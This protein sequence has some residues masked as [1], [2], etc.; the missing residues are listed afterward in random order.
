MKRI[1]IAYIT[2][3][4]PKDKT[5]WSGVH[6]FAWKALERNVGDVDLLGPVEAPLTLFLCKIL[7]GLS[8]LVLRKR[9]NYR[10]SVILSKAYAGIF[11]K[12]FGNTHYDLIVAPGG[13]AYI[14]FLQTTIPIFYFSDAT[15]ANLIN[16][17]KMLTNLLDWSRKQSLL[18]EQQAINTASFVS[19][20]SQWAADSALKDFHCPPEK[21]KVLPFGANFET[22]PDRTLA[23]RPR[24]DKVCKLF[25]LGVDWNHK[26]GP[27][28][29]D[30]LIEL[31]NLGIDA[32]LTVVGC[33]VP[34]EINHPKLTLVPFLSKNNPAEFRQLE[35]LYLESS[36]FLLPT[37]TE[38]YGICF[39]EAAAYGLPSI[40]GNSGGVSSSIGQGQSGYLLPLNAGGKEYAHLI[41]EIWNDPARYDQ[42]R[43]SSRNLFEQGRNWNAWSEGLREMIAKKS[44]G[45]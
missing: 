20:S 14:A 38:C 28:A 16:Y 19:Y 25:F 12:K 26:G 10:H 23:I 21:L 13:S 11:R 1:K 27:V 32:Q 24:E 8:M 31:L 3:L 22:A 34:P 41:A 2:G 33:T 43:I 15:N 37:R 40:A 39:C 17:R 18:I 30:T 4:D 42:L 29:L 35:Q 7:H 36:F 5:S 45:V 6:Y 9:F 44:I